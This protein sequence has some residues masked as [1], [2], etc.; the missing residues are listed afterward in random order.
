[1]LTPAWGAILGYYGLGVLAAAQM[2]KLSALVPLIAAEL[3]LSLTSA[4]AAVSLLEL[5]GATLG[6][7][8]GLLAQRAGLKR[9]LLAG[10]ACL[11]AGGAGGGLAQGA[12]SLLAWRVLEAAGFLG[13][14]VSAPVLIAAVAG[15]AAGIAL[16]LWSSF[17]PVGLALGAWVWGGAAAV[18]G[19]RS[20]VVGGGVAVALAGLAS[21][22]LLARTPRLASA[23]APGTGAD[24]GRAAERSGGDADRGDRGR[25]ADR[26]GSAAVWCLA[27]AFGCCTLGEVGLLALLPSFL[28]G[29]AG[30]PPALAGHWTG[31]ASIAAVA[32][33]VV[34]ALLL[35]RGVEPRGPVLVGVLAPALL[36]FGVFAGAPSLARSAGLAIVANAI[37]GLFFSLA[38]AALPAAAGSAAGMVRANGLLAQFGAGGALIGPPL[39]AAAAERAGWPAA[40]AVAMGLALLGVPLAWRG[41][42]ATGR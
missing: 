21:A 1:M 16:A 33:S 12:L 36:C 23:A 10:L 8:A 31:V 29:Q 24:R 17:V 38:F 27:A 11:A 28:V 14:I 15:P 39:M 40:G 37:W 41:L 5:G 26:G 30:T 22:A 19:W 4:A 32:G 42:S 13:V 3:D 20:A 18:L 7:V 2:G 25:A 9:T 35:R 6:A 34:A